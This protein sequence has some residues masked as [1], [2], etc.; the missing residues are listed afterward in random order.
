[1][2]KT[3]KS[4]TDVNILWKISTY[5]ILLLVVVVSVFPAI[6]MIST[7]IK[8][9][10]EQYDIPPQIIPDAPTMQNYVNVLTNSKMFDA[11]INS[12]II[13][14]C[15]VSITLFISVMAGYGMS[16]Y[17]FRGHGVLKV[18]LLFGQMIPSVVIIIPL[19][20]LVAK[21]GLLD[22][23][24]SLIMSDMALTIPMGVIMLS[25]FMDT[26]PKELD[27]AAK[28]DGCSGIGALFKVVLPVA[29]P[30]LIS[31]AIYTYIHAWEEFL[32]ALNL[33]TSTKTRTLPIAIHMF[34][35][36]F[37]VDWGATMA[38]SAVVAFPVLLI[39]LACNKYFVKGM[40]DGAVKG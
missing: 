32:F 34:A 4:V 36:E 8:L 12:V 21:T 15:V 33:S 22:T 39:F 13:T 28:I 23:H 37:S 17:K 24:F 11:F 10:T 6:W 20:F 40:A 31:V 19:Y 38:A 1:M 7:S 25:S 27:E 3:K 29:K 18:A 30:G 35:G 9:P 16:R 14:V 5:A 2:L 26:V